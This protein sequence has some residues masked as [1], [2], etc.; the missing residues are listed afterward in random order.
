MKR[1]KK[2]VSNRLRTIQGIE[3]ALSGCGELESFPGGP[4]EEFESIIENLRS[5]SDEEYEVL[6]SISDAL[7]FLCLLKEKT[8][9]EYSFEKLESEVRRAGLNFLRKFP[10]RHAVSKEQ[11]SLNR[12]MYRVL[13]ISPE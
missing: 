2:T 7:S 3:K 11:A 9:S 4:R 10:A 5:M 12:K 13:D 6:V 1:R 8:N